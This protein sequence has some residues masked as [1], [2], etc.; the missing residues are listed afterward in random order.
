[1]TQV[2]FKTR[3]SQ[4]QINLANTCWGFLNGTLACSAAL[5]FRRRPTY[6]TSTLGM[7][8]VLTALT[9]CAAEYKI[10]NSAAAG[11]AMVAMIFLFSPIYNIA[12][13]AL[14]YSMLPSL[15][16]S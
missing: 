9:I 8:L 6:L 7:C 3:K 5:R 2:G 4:Q 15:S 10:A 1:L 11:K 13:N 14:T 12:F 16:R